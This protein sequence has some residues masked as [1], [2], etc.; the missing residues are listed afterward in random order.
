MIQG[1]AALAQFYDRDTLEAV[2][3]KGMNAMMEIWYKPDDVA[4]ILE[5]LESERERIFAEQAE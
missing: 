1:T 2:A 5:R 4:K 3:D